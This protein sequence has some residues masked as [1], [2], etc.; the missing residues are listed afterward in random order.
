MMASSESSSCVAPVLMGATSA[1]VG[2]A[3]AMP[4]S[5]VFCVPDVV[6]AADL[7]VQTNQA[8]GYKVACSQTS[9]KTSQRNPLYRTKA[10]SVFRNVTVRTAG[11]DFRQFAQI[12]KFF[13]V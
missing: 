13:L 4:G 1:I 12:V 10:E 8:D 7:A 9:R 11:A 2:A 5:W 3:S 6:L